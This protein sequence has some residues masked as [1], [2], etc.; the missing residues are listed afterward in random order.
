MKIPK[1]L[2]NKIDK[3]LHLESSVR[4]AKDELE[5]T[6]QFKA[7]KK[8][9]EDYSVLEQHLIIEHSPEELK[10]ATGKEGYL[11]VTERSSYKISDWQEVLDFIKRNDAFDLFQRRI[12]TGAAIERELDGVTIPGLFKHTTTSIKPKLR[13]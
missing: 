5:K 8:L 10:A 9:E 3:L 6:Q 11:T 7:L 4:A 1:M 12:T 13:K 2:S